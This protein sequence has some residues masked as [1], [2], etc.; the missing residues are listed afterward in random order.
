MPEGAG[1]ILLEDGRLAVESLDES[2]K[3]SSKRLPANNSLMMGEVM[4]GESS[5]DSL[6]DWSSTLA[7]AGYTIFESGKKFAVESESILSRVLPKIPKSGV[8]AIKT[9]KRIPYVG[10]VLG[11]GIDG[12]QLYTNPNYSE[13]DFFL[14]VAIGGIAFIPFVGLPASLLLYT[15]KETGTLEKGMNTIREMEK[16]HTVDGINMAPWIGWGSK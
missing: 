8:I 4:S 10:F 6:K 1:L 13:G 16:M 12:V 7:I 9:L 3:N 11:I 14:N 5:D 2:T 15:M